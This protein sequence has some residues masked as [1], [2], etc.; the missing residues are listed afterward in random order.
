[1]PARPGEGPVS[2]KRAAMSPDVHSHVMPVAEVAEERSAAVL[3]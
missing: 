3:V 1:M 2:L